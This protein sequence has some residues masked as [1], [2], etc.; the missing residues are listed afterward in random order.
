VGAETNSEK[1]ISRTRWIDSIRIRLKFGLIDMTYINTDPDADSEKY[2]GE[3]TQFDGGKSNNAPYRYR[4][5]LI[6]D[7]IEADPDE[8]YEPPPLKRVGK[9]SINDLATWRWQKRTLD[10]ES[11][12]KLIRRIQE[13]DAWK[14]MGCRSGAD[15]ATVY[16]RVASRAFHEL[17][18]AHHHSI[19][20]I[21]SDYVPR[22]W[23]SRRKHKHTN[24]QLFEDLM[25]VGCFGLW[26]AAL[27]FD[28]SRGCRLWTIARP[29]IKGLIANEANYLRRHGY[30]SGDTVA[31]Y[32]KQEVSERSDTRLDR[33]I[34]DHLGSSP[35]ELLEGQKKLVK[36]PVFHSFEEA[37][38]AI[39]AA[40]VLEHSEVFSGGGDG[41][42][43]E[44]RWVHTGTED[45]VTTN[46]AKP[47]EEWRDLYESQNPLYWSPQL[48]AHQ[49]VSAI[50]DFWKGEFCYPPRAKAK[51]R[52]KTGRVLHPIIDNPYWMEPR[53]G[54]PDILERKPPYDP[55][56]R[57]AAVI[58]FK[59]GKTKRVYRQIRTGPVRRIEV[60]PELNAK[61]A[62]MIEQKGRSRNK[63]V[64][65][66]SKQ[67]PGGPVAEIVVLES[68]RGGKPR[69]HVSER[70]MSS[71]AG[72]RFA[73]AG[74]AG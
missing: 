66:E 7:D 53:E 25:A 10:A 13:R 57:E 64:R 54:A 70:H 35:E 65:P 11:E 28:F 34:F 52:P 60:T 5:N 49:E 72:E 59:G 62:G 30:S 29:K 56:R 9:P 22:G 33:Y 58:R 42:D 15:I 1:K 68:R 24:Q 23:W 41:C 74:I 55:D 63:N 26:N 44:R 47:V 37:A 18:A 50:V 2:D 69:L 6:V 43:I 48:R 17:L 38:D 14:V 40:N 19:R 3:F 4:A 21:A 8:A 31:R 51:P 20:P 71:C 46:V 27:E 61:Y 16:N 36:H 45:D 32:L 73:G 39:K 67:A 12:R